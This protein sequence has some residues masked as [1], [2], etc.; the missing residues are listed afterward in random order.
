MQAIVELG[1]FFD[2]KSPQTLDI[3]KK[4]IYIALY[5]LRKKH[6]FR[7]KQCHFRL[8]FIRAYQVKK[9]LI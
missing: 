1:I 2:R 4:K 9:N 3:L 8:S 5:L 7:S 6:I